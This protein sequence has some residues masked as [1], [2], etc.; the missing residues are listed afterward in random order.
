MEYIFIGIISLIPSILWGYF[1]WRKD[2]LEPEPF[3]MIFLS[4]LAGS[5]SAILLSI[6]RQWILEFF[7]SWESIISITIF[8]SV[9]EEFLKVLALLLCGKILRL[10]FTQV[11]DGAVYGVL[12]GLGFAFIENIIYFNA[13]Y[14]GEMTQEFIIVF[15]F[16][17][18]ASM[19]VHALSTGIFGLF[20]GYAIFSKTI[21]PFH[22]LSMIQLGR[23]IRHKIKQT[24]SLHILRTH[25][26][27]NTVSKHG[28]EKIEIIKEGF[29][30][31]VIIHC[32]SNLLLNTQWN[33][34]ISI[35]LLIIFIVLVFG[36]FSHQFIKKR[37]IKIYD[38]L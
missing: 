25:I 27:S 6:H 32:V 24:L 13:L 33:G 10:R 20:W 4:F 11:I 30:V 8:L 12:L 31:A 15:I 19:V 7:D 37:N 17:S 2:F 1:F 14:S 35:S 29:F 28:H 5:I 36:K 18:I 26:L 34:N 23:H 16:R 21:A 9:G 38:P 3:K 22:T